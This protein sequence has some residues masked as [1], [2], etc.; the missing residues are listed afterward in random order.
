MGMGPVPSTHKAL[1]RAG[2]TVADIDLFEINEAS[3][4]QAANCQKKLGIAPEKL[5][6]IGATIA[7]GH[8]FGMTASRLVGQALIEGKRRGSK[9][10]VVSMCVAGGASAAGLFEVA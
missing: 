5:D 7:I 4:S 9:Y 2:L 6:V 8:P 10:E 1:T 3:A